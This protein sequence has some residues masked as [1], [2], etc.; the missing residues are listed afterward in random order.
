MLTNNWLKHQSLRLK[1]NLLM[2]WQ[3]ITI[4]IIMPTI[5]PCVA[6]PLVKAA[7]GKKE[8]YADILHECSGSKRNKENRQD[9]SIC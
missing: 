8:N 9:R 7:Q 4:A 3:H 1:R 6:I 2:L 5:K